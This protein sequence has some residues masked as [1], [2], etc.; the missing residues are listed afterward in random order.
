MQQPD[1]LNTGWWRQCIGQTLKSN[2]LSG[3]KDEMVLTA[4]ADISHIE[5]SWM[6]MIFFVKPISHF[7]L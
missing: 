1:V 3:V 7:I 6:K 2:L 4:Y 5:L